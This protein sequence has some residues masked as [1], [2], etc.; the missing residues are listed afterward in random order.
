M[1][2]PETPYGVVQ[3]G[4]G[5][6]RAGRPKTAV[7]CDILGSFSEESD[8]STFKPALPGHYEGILVKTEGYNYFINHLLA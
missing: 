1:C 8:N 7:S 5:M 6:Q 4:A 2:A 3:E